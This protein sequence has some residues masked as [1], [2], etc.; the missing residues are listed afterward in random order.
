MYYSDVNKIIAKVTSG[1]IILRTAIK[2]WYVIIVILNKY[3]VKK[4]IAWYSLSL[5]NTGI[6]IVNYK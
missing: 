2:L 4:L 6:N 1:K 5:L 3:V